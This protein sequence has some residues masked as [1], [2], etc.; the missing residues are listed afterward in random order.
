MLARFAAGLRPCHLLR[1][2]PL[3]TMIQTERFADVLLGVMEDSQD[4]QALFDYAEAHL[5]L[6][7]LMERAFNTLPAY[8]R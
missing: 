6:I 5:G 4:D 1:V 3:F 8:D 2:A 7:G